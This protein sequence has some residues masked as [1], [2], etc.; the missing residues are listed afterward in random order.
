MFTD[1]QFY[2]SKHNLKL[3]FLQAS[4][5]ASVCFLVAYGYQTVAV[6][7]R[8]VKYL[9]LVE[10]SFLLGIAEH[11]VKFSFPMVIWQYV[12]RYAKQGVKL[13]LKW[14]FG[15]KAP[16]P[17]VVYTLA[18]VVVAVVVRL[19]CQK[20]PPNMPTPPPAP[21]TQVTPKK[22]PPAIAP[23]PPSSRI[24]ARQLQHALET[25]VETKA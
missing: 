1:K 5:L 16:D 21:T 24:R 7:C 9:N 10:I 4:T 25:L 12:W 11:L 6:C 20:S 13:T 17:W 23:R 3:S 14:G 15:Y 19:C 18:A 22:I 8:N 2:L